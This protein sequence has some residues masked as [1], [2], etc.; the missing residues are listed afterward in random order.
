M[1]AIIAIVNNKGG[2]GKTTITTNLAH[3]L[4]NL[5]QEVLVIDADSQC[6]TSSFF[7]HGDVERVPAPNLYELLEDDAADVR[8]CI[9][10]APEYSR[11]AVLPTH[12]D[13]AG[14][15]P[16]IIQRPDTGIRLMR[17]KLRD[18]AKTKYDFTL[19][20]CPPNLGTFVMMAMVAAD[21]VLVPLESGSKYSIDGIARTVG[22]IDDIRSEGQNKDLTLLRCLLNKA[23][24]RTIVAR[25]T[26]ERL[27]ER[28]P[29]RVFETVLSASTDL[30]Q[31][32]YLSETVIRSKP[33]SQLARL[34]RQLANEVVSLKEI[35]TMQDAPS[36]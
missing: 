23:R 17:D 9:H 1:G 11:I 3:A 8:D 22:L 30:Q 26:H 19:I 2:E 12:P 20:D 21:F 32:E 33:N 6:N 31:S 29:G 28:F 24:P 7:F 13:L 34:F 16:V 18:Y 5:Q 10:A 4:A 14:L 15:E 36:A 27:R 35:T 25:E